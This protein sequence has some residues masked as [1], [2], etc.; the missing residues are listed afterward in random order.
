MDNADSYKNTLLS[1]TICQSSDYNMQCALRFT[2]RSGGDI[3]VDS[4]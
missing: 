4:M 1:I 2:E 3:V